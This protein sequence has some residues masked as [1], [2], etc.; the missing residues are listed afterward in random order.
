VTDL[1]AVENV[2]ALLGRVNLIAVEVRGALL[3]F[4]EVLDGPQAA[5]RTVDLLVEHAPQA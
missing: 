4:G 5:L 3:E 2:H 1:N